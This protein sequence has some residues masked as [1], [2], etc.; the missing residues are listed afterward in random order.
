MTT[1][2][3]HRAKRTPTYHSWNAMKQRCSNAN[4]EDYQHYGGRGIKVIA[5]WSSFA[6][7]LADMGERPEGTT[8][9]RID[10]NGNY[11]PENC[12]WA[13]R[14]TQANN[15]RLNYQDAYKDPEAIAAEEKHWDQTWGLDKPL[16]T[17]DFIE[18]I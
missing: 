13:D 17:K 4:R 14:S 11:C 10:V 2:H 18:R 15:K 3:G 5:D 6:Q 16:W 1:K 7:F 8:L 9:D 12:R